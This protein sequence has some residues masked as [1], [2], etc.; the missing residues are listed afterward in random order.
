MKCHVLCNLQI[1]L[2]ALGAHNLVFFNV[3]R[4]LYITMF[5]VEVPLN[6]TGSINTSAGQ[7]ICVLTK[8]GLWGYRSIFLLFEE[9]E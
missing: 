4:Q 5:W 2:N 1:I 6:I 8:L 7:L 3:L 9:Y